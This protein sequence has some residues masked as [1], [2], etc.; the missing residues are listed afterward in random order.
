MSTDTIQPTAEQVALAGP[1]Y[2]KDDLANF[3]EE[4]QREDV[5]LESGTIQPPASTA[6]PE[7]DTLTVDGDE[8]EQEQQRLAGKFDSPE[9]LEKAYLELQK[10]LGQP[11]DEQL[12]EQPQVPEP[13]ESFSREEAL[14]FYGETVVSAAEREGIDLA[15]W[16][17]AVQRG[18]D[19][20]EMRERLAGAM[21]I[22]PELIERYEAGFRPEEAQAAGLSPQDQES[23]K[24]EVGGEARFSQLSQ[25]ALSNLSP[26][27]L[28]DYN[29]AINTGSAGAA[30]AAVRW[31][32]SRA[33]SADKE[34]NLIMASGGNANPGLDVFETEEEA[35]EAKAA[36]TKAGK[37]RYMV[38][39]K[40]RRYVDAKFARSNIFL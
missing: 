22:P 33:A 3:L 35:M 11:R 28:D 16:D 13:A 36:L 30:R 2:A 1:G 34:P 15:Q 40:Y 26:Q 32:A 19:T 27:E 20:S 14:G 7:Y 31:L 10:K 4:I 24:A 6:S 39:E 37:P 5:A 18:E 9:E 17:A 29:S 21:G 25:W 8:V 12:D 23:I 38:D